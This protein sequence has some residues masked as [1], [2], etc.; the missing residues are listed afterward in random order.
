[1]K[2]LLLLALL[3]SLPAFAEDGRVVA[4]L[5]QGDT[6]EVGGDTRGALALFRQAEAIEPENVGVLLRIS[7]QYGD[8]IARTQ[9]QEA[10]Q[11][12]AERALTYAQRAVA[13]DPENAKARLSLAICYGRLTDFVGSKAKLEY[14]RVIKSEVSKSLELDP[15]DDFAWHV[16]GRWHFGV[17]NV[18]GML[19]A[20]ARLIYGG[21]PPASNDEAARCLQKAIELAP[22]RLMHHAEL[23]RVHSAM[24]KKELALQDWQ[25]VLGIRAADTED[26]KYQQEARAAL[27][28]ARPRRSSKESRYTTQR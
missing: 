24:G 1:V 14:S 21:L 9:P 5:V 17:A 2:S 7:K 18:N 25:N 10:A 27:E 13:L 28:A 23:A 16:L 22:Q 15:T 11:K 20:M 3:A 19:K 8:L 6:A 26:V 12:T 4:L